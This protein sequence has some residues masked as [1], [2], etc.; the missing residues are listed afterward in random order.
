[1]EQVRL[2]IVEPIRPVYGKEPF[3]KPEWSFEFKY[4]GF[5]GLLYIGE[6]AKFVSRQQKDLTQ[7]DPLA[8][9]IKEALAPLVE[10]AIFDGE[11]VTKDETDRPIFSEILR[12]RGNPSYMAFDLL[13]FNGEDLRNKPLGERR[14]Y[15]HR[16]LRN[17]RRR[18]LK[19]IEEAFYVG[20]EK[21]Q[22]L[23]NLMC[24][25]DL[26][27]VIA[28]K[29]SDPYTKWTKWYKIKNPSYSQALGRRDFFD[30]ARRRATT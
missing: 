4:D 5:R 20:G 12:R 18:K 22:E 25:H 14:G 17:L 3:G 7:F 28:K 26:E 23:Y 2:P 16:V 30:R 21:G 6:K 9:S 27:G 29:L 1:M 15:L 13:W 11:L 24:E 8:K 19:L 10:T